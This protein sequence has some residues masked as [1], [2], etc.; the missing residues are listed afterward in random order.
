MHMIVHLLCIISTTVSEVVCSQPVSDNGTIIVSWSYVHT[1]GLPLSNVSVQYTFQQG[2]STVTKTVSGVAIND[3]TV[4]IHDLV[5][6]QEYTFT[7]TAKNM[8]GLFNA[9]CLHPV[10]HL[11]GEC[12]LH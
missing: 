11:L 5:V 10:Y 12:D 4:T 1:G 3:V 8:E 6:G 7:V 2:L 9:V